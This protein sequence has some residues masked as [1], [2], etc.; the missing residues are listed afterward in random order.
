MDFSEIPLIINDTN[1]ENA[2]AIMGSTQPTLRAED[3]KIYDAAI[4]F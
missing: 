1:H 4:T 3:L 2:L